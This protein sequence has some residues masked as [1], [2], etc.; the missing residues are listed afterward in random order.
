MNE[1]IQIISAAEGSGLRIGVKSQHLTFHFFE[2][3]DPSLR[4]ESIVFRRSDWGNVKH[5]VHVAVGGG[6]CLLRTAP[7]LTRA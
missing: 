4:S 2:F 7:I 6:G 1:A 3:A 5:F